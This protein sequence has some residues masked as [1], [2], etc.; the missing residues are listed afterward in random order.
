MKNTH[1]DSDSLYGALDRK[2][3][4]IQAY[5]DGNQLKQL[6]L[7]EMYLGLLKAYCEC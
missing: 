6:L 2:T 1:R 3:R 5:K 4:G 7:G